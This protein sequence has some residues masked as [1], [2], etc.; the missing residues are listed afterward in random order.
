AGLLHLILGRS[1]FIYQEP[2][3]LKIS[4]VDGPEIYEYPSE[5]SLLVEESLIS[6]VGC[7]VSVPSLGGSTLTNYTP[8][9]VEEFQ[10][11][12]TRSST[13]QA[14]PDVAEVSPNATESLLQE[15]DRPFSEGANADI[16]F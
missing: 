6:P 7:S 15:C 5:T 9:G 13:P 8:K 2:K 14:K 4:F 12:V 1:F 11:G 16:L 3:K 10:P